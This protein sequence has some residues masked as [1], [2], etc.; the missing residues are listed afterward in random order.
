MSLL[1]K[2]FAYFG[3]LLLAGI[4]VLA[5]LISY[6]SACPSPRQSGGEGPDSFQAYVYRC[7]GDAEVLEST[8]LPIPEPGA[9]QVLVKVHAASV[10]PLDWHYM[11]GSPYLMRLQA[12][13]GA[14]DNP[15]I[16]RDVAGTV[17]AVGEGV[18]RFAVGDA[19]FGGADGAFAE[20][21]LMRASGSIAAKPD[22][23]SFEQAAAVPVAALTALQ[24]LRDN[25]Q[26][27]P[28]ERVLINGASGGVGTFAVQIADSLG[29]HVTGVSS[30][31]NHDLVR[32]L[33]ADEVIDYRTADYTDGEARYDV[34]IDN[35]GNH[36][37]P[38]NVSVLSAG[39][40]LVMVGASKGDWVAPLVNPLLSLVYQPFV[41]QELMVLMARL[42]GDD[43]ATV[44]QMM[45]DGEVV[46]VID[47][48]FSLEELP[49][50]IR[51][52]ETGRARGKILVQVSTRG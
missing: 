37:I 46:A 7:Y 16:G 44:A 12:G 40:R 36:S 28:G 31:R 48:R 3:L 18:T 47:R 45:A 51:Y 24:A 43:L 1:R 32:S 6:D 27:A 4:A 38:A 10:N 5:V 29:A 30:A 8:R 2:I 20:Y 19:V 13:I 21:V 49:A 22:A 39:G 52:S 11:H 35:V 42:D 23:L 17:A 14:P 26:V 41:E 15:R 34:I 33:G 25:A 50:A 9:G